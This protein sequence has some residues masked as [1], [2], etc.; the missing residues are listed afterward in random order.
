MTEVMEL[1]PDDGPRSS[2]SIGPGF[3]RCSGISPKFARRF[4]EGIGKLT[5]NTSGDRRKKTKRL[6]TR[7]SEATGMAGLEMKGDLIFLRKLSSTLAFVKGKFL[8]FMGY[9]VVDRRSSSK[10]FLSIMVRSWGK[11]WK[12]PEIWK[13]YIS[14]HGG[15]GC[16]KGAAAI[17][18]R[19]GSDVH[20]Y[21]KGG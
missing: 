20:G 13:C 6:T 1:Q 9:H 15:V 11:S 14:N 3:G 19:R 17:G 4:A 18:G 8:P 10:K 21:Y 5:G 16:S 2:L 7:M 12:S